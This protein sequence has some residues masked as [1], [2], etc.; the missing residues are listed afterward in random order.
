[1]FDP[2]TREVF[3]EN[4]L[5]ASE[6]DFH[7]DQQDYRETVRMAM[8][9]ALFDVIRNLPPDLQLG[10]LDLA[11]E[12]TDLPNRDEIVRRIRQ[13]NGQS[14]PGEQDSPDAVAKRE[15]QAAAQQRDQQLT[16]AERTAKIRR[17]EAAA[18]RDEQTARKTM[19]DTKASAM[20]TAG[21][22]A[23]ALPL[24]PA[25]DRLAEFP[26]EPGVQS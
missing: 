23:A 24:A 17:D 22:V 25:A 12:L 2:I 21:L 13:L 26:A 20:N 6:A 9:E 18:L 19:V 8:A 3:F 5:T 4:D 15:A 14:A 11:L 16:E 7:V 10:L 1:V